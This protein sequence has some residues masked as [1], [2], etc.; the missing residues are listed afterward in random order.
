MEPEAGSSTIGKNLLRL[1]KEQGVTQD[2]LAAKA[3]VSRA[4]IIKLESGEEANPKASTVTTLEQALGVSAGALSSTDASAG[5]SPL[6]PD[7]ADGR[8]SLPQFLAAARGVLEPEDVRR[9]ERLR[10]RLDP[11]GLTRRAWLRTVI[12]LRED[13]DDDGGMG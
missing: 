12:D 9:L 10:T 13:E 2:Q 6:A 1:R 5:E 3:G 7:A 8:I 11:R 4:T